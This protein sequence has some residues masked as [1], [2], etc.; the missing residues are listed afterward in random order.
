MTYWLIV[1]TPENWNVIKEK[2]VVG[3]PG[4]NK[5]SFLKVQKGDECLVYIRREINPEKRSEPAVSGIFEVISS[6]VDK[7]KIFTPPPA[8][9]DE[10]FPLRLK[11][12]LVGS[13]IEP[14]PFKPLISQLSFILNKRQWGSYLQ[15]RALIALPEKDYKIIVSSLQKES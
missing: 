3:I 5:T 9:Q 2:H 7:Q 6:T 8:R 4:R 13:P 12:K 11:V 14:I 1:T 10:T 15:G